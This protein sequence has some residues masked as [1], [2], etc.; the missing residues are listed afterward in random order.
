M[1]IITVNELIAVLIQEKTQ[2]PD[3]L[4]FSLSEQISIANKLTLSTETEVDN[5]ILLL[6]KLL[7]K[8]TQFS[9]FPT[10]EDE[11][12]IKL[13]S[14]LILVITEVLIKVR[15][16]KIKE[17]CLTIIKNNGSTRPHIKPFIDY[18]LKYKEEVQK[19]SS[20]S[21]PLSEEVVVNVTEITHNGE[22]VAMVKD[23]PS[24]NGENSSIISEIPTVT[25]N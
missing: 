25:D 7:N 16:I 24:P 6:I 3:E 21:N 10:K 23:F 15:P 9:F 4:I 5:A 12:F 13:L 14:M 1:S 20:S 11:K 18:V 19:P 22:T 2:I 8:P 17:F